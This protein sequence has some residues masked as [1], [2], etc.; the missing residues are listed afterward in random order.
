VP[1]GTAIDKR[2]KTPGE[3]EGRT[4]RVISDLL[5][6]EIFLIQATIESAGALGDG[7]AGLRQRLGVEREDAGQAEPI[8]NL[9]KHTRDRVLE[10]YT[11]RFSHF[12]ELVN[13]DLAA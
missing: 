3:S 6:A 4:E 2:Q 8:A 13:D 9:L 11:T 1:N 10:P 5:L 7:I 12:R